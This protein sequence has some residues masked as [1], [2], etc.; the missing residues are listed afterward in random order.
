MLVIIVLCWNTFR[1][2]SFIS[3]DLYQMNY[4][5]KDAKFA[6]QFANRD[7]IV[8]ILLFLEHVQE[9]EYRTRIFRGVDLLEPGC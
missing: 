3:S 7:L 2:I 1:K 5:Q 8:I 9:I 6:L 4:A